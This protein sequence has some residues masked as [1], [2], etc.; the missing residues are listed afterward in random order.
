ME[1][2]SCHTNTIIHDKVHDENRNTQNY[3]QLSY[4]IS[5]HFKLVSDHFDIYGY[6][7]VNSRDQLI[8]TLINFEKPIN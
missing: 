3:D 5:H 7:L 6:I 8:M 2:H 4:F 1:A